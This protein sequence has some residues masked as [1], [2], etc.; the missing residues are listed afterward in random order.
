MSDKIRIGKNEYAPPFVEM[1]DEFEDECWVMDQD[2]NAIK[3]TD[4]LTALNELASLRAE[5][6]A[7]KA[8]V[9][10]F[11]KVFDK[12]WDYY[13]GHNPN[14]AKQEGWGWI[15]DAWGELKKSAGLDEEH[16]DA[17]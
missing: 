10:K 14:A 8:R 17:Q 5:N 12:W 2:Q 16:P 6:A 13:V 11:H 7:L 15:D 9:E 3:L 4:V 1:N